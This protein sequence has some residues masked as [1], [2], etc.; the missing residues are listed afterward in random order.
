MF[1]LDQNDC[2]GWARICSEFYNAARA[3]DRKEITLDEISKKLDAGLSYTFN[4]DGTL[5]DIEFY[6]ILRKKFENGSGYYGWSG[7]RYFLY[8]YEIS[9][10]SESRHKKIGIYFKFHGKSQIN[11]VL[12]ALVE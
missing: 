6:N 9:L 2:S 12:A 10:L 5:R 7:L 1:R 8:E 3:L 4:D 11:S